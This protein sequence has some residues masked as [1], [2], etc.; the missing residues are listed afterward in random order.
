MSRA[1]STVVGILTSIALAAV[2]LSVFE[3]NQYNGPEGALRRFVMAVTRNDRQAALE[4]TGGV[5]GLAFEQLATE[6]RLHLRAGGVFEFLEIRR[7]NGRAFAVVEIRYPAGRRQ[8][9]WALVR[10]GR[11]WYVDVAGSAR[12]HGW[13]A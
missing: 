11:R 5:G 3:R 1:R 2:T 4:A 12:L 9:L 8:S 10:E 7:Q 6:V 13:P